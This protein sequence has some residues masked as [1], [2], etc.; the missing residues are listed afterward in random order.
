MR[1]VALLGSTGSIG[2]SALT[3]LARHTGEFRVVALAANRNA[4]ELVQQV[5]RLGPALAV[6]VDEDAATANG[7]LPAGIRTGRA[8]LLEAAA[9][10]DADIVI[11]AVVG[12]AGLEATLAALR[13]GK[14]LA[15]ANKESLV[16]G[17]PLVREA[18]RAGG[19][20]LVPID[21][22]HSAILQCIAGAPGQSVQRMILTASGGP[23]RSWPLE[24]LATVTPAEAL[25]HPTWEMGAKITV[26][27]AT[28][29]NKALEV[30]EAHFLF[31]VPYDAVE[32]V[33]H[34]QSI[35]HSMVEFVDGSLLAQL[36][37][38]TM[39]L[40]ILY[41]LTHPARLADSGTR[42]FDPVAAATLTFERVDSV[43]FRAFALGIDA[44]RAGGTA[45]AVF[46]A[47]NEVA[48]AGFLRGAVPFTA[49]PDV[50]ARALDAHSPAPADSLDTVMASDRRA[51]ETAAA[52]MGKIC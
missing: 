7:P 26:D 43:R 52:A 31:D 2:R 20:E 24:R 39:E 17:G 15:L 9:H 30:I 40:P 32:V 35:I 33:V 16:T 4:A 46:N 10:P 50:I 6:L 23:F 41:A 21:S 51:R 38:P 47:A 22:E 1:G 34:P 45:P 44:G 49:I 36:G 27:S 42:R 37:F 48:V 12:A 3:V 11:N 14:R 18:L 25:R 5:A 19:G 29:A 28:L 8:A 13:A